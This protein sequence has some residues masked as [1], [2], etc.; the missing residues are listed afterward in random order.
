M[1]TQRRSIRGIV[2]SG[3]INFLNMSKASAMIKVAH[4]PLQQLMYNGQQKPT[5]NRVFTV[6]ML[7]YRTLATKQRLN[8][9]TTEP[10]TLS[11]IVPNAQVL[12]NDNVDNHYLVIVHVQFN[13]VI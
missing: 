4:V 9:A 8:L 3:H 2:C 10:N 6:N 11:C 1:A 7:R 5:I 13:V 12:V